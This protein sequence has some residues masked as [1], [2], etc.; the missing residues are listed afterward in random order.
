MYGVRDFRGV[1]RGCSI[2]VGTVLPL[3]CNGYRG[4]VVRPGRPKCHWEKLHIHI[5]GRIVLRWLRRTR[6]LGVLGHKYPH[7]VLVSPLRNESFSELRRNSRYSRSVSRGLCGGARLHSICTPLTHNGEN[8]ELCTCIPCAPLIPVR[9]VGPTPLV[10]LTVGD[11]GRAQ[12]RA[13]IHRAL[14]EGS[15]AAGPS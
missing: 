9:V 3:P 7:N 13:L 5:R 11:D 1:A 6:S 10:K 15:R 2:S 8:V 12:R 14:S 4:G